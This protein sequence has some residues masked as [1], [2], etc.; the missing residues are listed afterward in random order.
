M[1]EHALIEKLYTSED[2]LKI[3]GKG[4]YELLR[5]ELKEMAPAGGEH[6][7]IAMRAGRLIDIHVAKEKLG[8]VFA[9]ETGFKISSNPDTVRA[10]D[11][12]FI[13]KDRISSIPRGFVDIVPDL[14]VEVI[15][16]GD[17][18]SEVEDKVKDWLEA[19]VREVWVINP[20]WKIVTL[21]K[22]ESNCVVL[23]EKDELDGGNILKGFKCKVKELFS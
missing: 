16:P 10:P 6:G 3:S 2:L 19:G 14:A 11:A 9:A 4:K 1:A 7:V 23:T 15:S 13:A 12:A 20:R 5:G 17:I 21:H 22:P 18:Y 8:V